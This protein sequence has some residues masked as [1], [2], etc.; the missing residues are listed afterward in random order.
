[1]NCRLMNCRRMN[2]TSEADTCCARHSCPG[3]ALTQ[4]RVAETRALKKTRAGHESVLCHTSMLHVVAMSLW[5]ST[6]ARRG[7]SSKIERCR[8]K[9]GLAMDGLDCRGQEE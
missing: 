5:N 3:K 6:S 2:C 9:P 7:L 4:T 8:R 1:M